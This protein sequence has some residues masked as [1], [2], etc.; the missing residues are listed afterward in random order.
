M[1]LLN[2]ADIH[3]REPDCL[4]L[5]TD[6]D[7]AFRSCLEDDAEAFCV[8]SNA[9]VDAILVVGDIA[10]KAA[11]SEYEVAKEW[12]LSLADK[13]GCPRNRIYVVPGNHDV[14]RRVC[15]SMAGIGNAQAAIANA[16]SNYRE[17]VFRRQLGDEGAARD[18]FR[19][20]EE[21]NRF[22]ASFACNV[23][24]G[25]PFWVDSIDI[26]QGMT[27]RLFGLTSTF[28]SGLDGRDEEPGRLYLS[29]LTCPQD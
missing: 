16:T 9:P 3:F 21:Y 26:G 6:P 1:R 15:G 8:S 20:L 24:P 18:L 13:C 23:Y 14:D 19:P 11:R 29:P 10:F 27:L 4:N 17:S 28:I 25:Q 22:A 2:I 12:L 5:A 7:S